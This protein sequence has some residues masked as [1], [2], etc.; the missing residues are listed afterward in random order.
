MT[1]RTEAA[2]ELIAVSLQRSAD[3]A[4]ANL[5]MSM[6]TFEMNRANFQRAA[7]EFESN[8]A[9]KAMALEEQK[10]R[11]EASARAELR[12]LERLASA[13]RYLDL[14]ERGDIREAERME[15]GKLLMGAKAPDIVPSEFKTVPPDDPTND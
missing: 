6:Q 11:S 13:K 15:L 12:E 10:R 4:S 7:A 14:L 2:L 1:E 8:E 3:V 9:V 5:R